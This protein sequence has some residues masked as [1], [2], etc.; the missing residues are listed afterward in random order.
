MGAEQPPPPCL[1]DD[2]SDYERALETVMNTSSQ[3]HPSSISPP[4]VIP[5][6][7]LPPAVVLPDI[8][9]PSLPPPRSGL[10]ILPVST[11]GFTVI[12]ASSTTALHSGII[13]STLPATPIAEP[14]VSLGNSPSFL[15][16]GNV[17]T[18]PPHLIPYSRKGGPAL[19]HS[20]A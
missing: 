1:V 13:S 8:S 20:Q 7:P 3:H 14:R 15:G 11:G 10:D 17:P 9:P 6:S 2:S 18:P 12:A 19:P 4:I 5:D 16:R